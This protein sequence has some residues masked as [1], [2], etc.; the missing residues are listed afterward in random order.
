MRTVENWSE[1]A[2]YSGLK[3]AEVLDH[4]QRE[5]YLANWNQ[6]QANYGENV[7]FQLR[8]EQT[9]LR[10]ETADFLYTEFTPLA[11]R[12]KSGMRPELEQLVHSLTSRCESDRDKALSIMR[13]TRDLYQRVDGRQLFFGGTEEALIRKGEQLCECLGR[14]M[15]ALAEIAGIPGRIVM[16][17]IG[18]HIVSELY[19]DGSWAYF[20]PRCGVYFVKPDGRLASTWELWR[21]PELTLDQ[22]AEVKA[23]VSP[24]WSW[25]ERARI[26]RER[27]FHPREVNGFQNYSLADAAK[28]NYEWLTHHDLARN[29]MN[30]AARRYRAA[31]ERVLGSSFPPQS[32]TLSLLENQIVSGRV[33][34]AAKPEGFP[35]PPVDLAFYVDGNPV[36]LTRSFET[37]PSFDGTLAWWWETNEVPDGLREVR[38]Q[39]EEGGE[40]P[41]EARVRVHVANERAHGAEGMRC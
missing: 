23:D 38:V 19:V 32:L 14:L 9:L 26:C 31:I 37:F 16:H 12:Y 25:E 18:G 22:P 36:P 33:L 20:D 40:R 4:E 1:L 8:R 21:N 24:R 30:R 27:Y 10:P 39:T 15:V 28:Y 11:T 3:A 17:V 6:L 5:A 13:F 34:V 35:V 2:A 7:E 41:V 29:G